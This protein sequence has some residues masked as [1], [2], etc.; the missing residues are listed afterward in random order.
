MPSEKAETVSRPTGGGHSFQ[1]QPGVIHRSFLH[2]DLMLRLLLVKLQA[3]WVDFEAL[4]D[5]VKALAAT[6]SVGWPTSTPQSFSDHLLSREG[7]AVRRPR[8]PWWQAALSPSH[9]PCMGPPDA[10]I[11]L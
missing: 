10:R 1:A 2:D 6:F 3:K 7:R 4:D 11:K 8:T 9:Q 5:R